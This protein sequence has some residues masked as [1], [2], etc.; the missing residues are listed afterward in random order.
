MSVVG[1][2][3]WCTISLLTKTWKTRRQNTEI[4]WCPVLDFPVQPGAKINQPWGKNRPALTYGKVW[5]HVFLKAILYGYHFAE[6]KSCPLLFLG[7]F[8]NFFAS[9]LL[10][11]FYMFLCVYSPASKRALGS[12][13]VLSLNVLPFVMHFALV[14]CNVWIKVDITHSRNTKCPWNHMTIVYMP[15]VQNN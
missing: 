12:L 1:W 4:S 2:N 14:I 7:S 8:L 6:M 3:I 9:H 10:L 13:L 15:F 5:I 11:L